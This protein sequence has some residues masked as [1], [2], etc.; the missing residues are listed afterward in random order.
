[1]K[2]V[3]ILTF[4]RAINYGA[5]LQAYALKCYI[6]DQGNECEIIDYH[7]PAIEDFYNKV[8]LRNDSVKTKV[9]KIVTWSIQKKRN[10]KFRDFIGNILLDGKISKGYTKSD[11][12]SVN[13]RYD[14]FI[15]GS[16]QVWSPFCT[17]GD[18]TYFL[19]FVSESQKRN[20]YAACVGLASDD[21]L[22]SETIVNNLQKFNN[23]S[24]REESTQNKLTAIMS[25]KINNPISLDIDPTLLLDAERWNRVA[26]NVVK[27]HYIF[28]YSLSMPKEIV[29]FSKQ[30][31]K[32]KKEKIIFCTLDNFFTM[33]NKKSTVNASPEEFLGYIKNA[34][35]VITNSFH[36]TVF[37]VI[38]KKNFYVIKN[39][40]PNH[41]N[42]RLINILC[43]L[44][45]ENRLIEEINSFKTIN[46][47]EYSNVE[48]KLAVMRESS[49][50]YI[51]R[52]ISE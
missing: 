7:C 41:D 46:G 23:I 39:K 44:G 11:I 12:Y 38:F 30:F 36:G 2:K 48:Q 20:S 8:I 4:H 15:T 1:M 21:F 52:I 28:V 50:K 31:A 14:L 5:C 34:D 22:K 19:N 18:L 26:T 10:L 35:F 29:E 13:T 43:L 6:E 16:D 3:G 51:C 24:V 37:S 9:K 42:S 47:I 33:K 45:L 17:G 27:E 40:N 49:R 25:G 32:E